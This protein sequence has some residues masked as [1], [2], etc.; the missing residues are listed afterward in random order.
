MLSQWSPNKPPLIHKVARP[1]FALY[2]L[3]MMERIVSD[4]S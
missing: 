2:A 3:F 1:I 4:A